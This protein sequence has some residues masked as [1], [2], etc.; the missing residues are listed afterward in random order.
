MEEVAEVLVMVVAERQQPDK[1]IA[2]RVFFKAAVCFFHVMFPVAIVLF[3]L[4]TGRPPSP[5][6]AIVKVQPARKLGLVGEHPVR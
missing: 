5:W 2:V 1:L 4:T 6:Y 3:T